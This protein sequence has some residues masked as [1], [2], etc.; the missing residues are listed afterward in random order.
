MQ[1][2]VPAQT[3]PEQHSDVVVHLAGL[4]H[5]THT[6]P[7]FATSHL[8]PAQQSDVVAQGN[9]LMQH[10]PLAH[11]WPCGQQVPLQQVSPVVQHAVP[12]AV[13]PDG[14]SHWQVVASNTC[15]PGQGPT[16][17]PVLGHSNVPGPHAHLAVLGSQKPL[18]HSE[19]CRHPC[20]P[21]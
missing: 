1:T 11:T 19:F 8:Y 17:M 10:A 21:L 4:V 18:Q 12:Q 16:H 9:G 13:V 20:P 3:K 14:H 15:S 6:P 5:G 2:P 7:P